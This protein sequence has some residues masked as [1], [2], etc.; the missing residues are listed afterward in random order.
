MHDPEKNTGDITQTREFTLLSPY[1]KCA[2][3]LYIWS[4]LNTE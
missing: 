3:Y 4:Y 2:D 1:L